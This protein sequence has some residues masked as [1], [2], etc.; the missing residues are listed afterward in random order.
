MIRLLAFEYLDT[1][2]VPERVEVRRA[3]KRR[4]DITGIAANRSEDRNAAKPVERPEAAVRTTRR[5]LEV[6]EN[7]RCVDADTLVSLGSRVVKAHHQVGH[8]DRSD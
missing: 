3:H 7:R 6:G 1:L 4:T 5:K 2:S 8:A